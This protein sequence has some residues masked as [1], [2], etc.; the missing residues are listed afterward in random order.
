MAPLFGTCTVFLLRVF[1]PKS[2][3]REKQV[4][5]AAEAPRRDPVGGAPAG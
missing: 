5:Q 4:R 1:W 2:A 3:K